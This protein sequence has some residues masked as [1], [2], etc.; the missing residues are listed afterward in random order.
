MVEYKNDKVKDFLNELQKVEQQETGE[1]LQKYFEGLARTLFNKIDILAGNDRYSLAEIEF[2]YRNER[3]KGDQYKV[4][5]PRMKSAGSLFWHLSG[6]DIC[7]KTDIEKESYYGGI[8]IRSIVKEKDG[9]LITGPMCCSD[10]LLNSCVGTGKNETPAIIPILV[11]KEIESDIEP[12]S[13]IRQGI[14]ADKGE[15]ALD[16]CFY[17]KRSSWQNHK[18][19]Y[20]SARPDKRKDL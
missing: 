16:F 14:E 19:Y 9:S 12:M 17:T 18:K 7:F 11:D 15:G 4:T 5:Y 20:Y 2:Y 6:I 13:T 1:A 8:L 3:F 10:E